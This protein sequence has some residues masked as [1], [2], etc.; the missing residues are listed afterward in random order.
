MKFRTQIIT[1]A[2]ALAIAPL[3]VSMTIFLF[4]LYFG[5]GEKKYEG[6]YLISR[7]IDEELYPL[8]YDSDADTI[9]I[10]RGI[11]LC[12]VNERGLIVFS[13]IP[14]IRKGM[15]FNP[16]LPKIIEMAKGKDS[17]TI[18][19]TFPFKGKRWR[20]FL[21]YSD[22]PEYLE[23]KKFDWIRKGLYSSIYLLVAGV[24][25]GSL[26]VRSILRTT[27][28]LEFAIKKISEGEL[29][30]TL[31]KKGKDEFA[32]IIESF[33]RMR[34]A[35]KEEHARKSRFLMAIS[36][37]LK[38]PLTSIRGYVEAI[39]DGLVTDVETMGR[40]IGIIANKSTVLEERISSLIDFA[41]M[42][43]GE[44][45]IKN[46]RIYLRSFLENLSR[47]Y[48]EDC[49]IL[50]KHYL[51]ECGISDEITVTGDPV[52]FERALE[53]LFVNS[54]RHTLSGT[55]IFFR[56]YIENDIPVI[57]LGDNGDGIDDKDIRYI[58]EPFYRGTNSRREQGMGLGLSTA[59]SIFEAHGWEISVSSE[60]GKGTV[61]RIIL[62]GTVI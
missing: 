23:N 26:I 50:D 25:A 11:E 51:F 45:K 49:E 62:H 16:L 6:R 54:V 36:H 3:V 2:T 21:V 39:Q 32:V 22:I 38:T 27:G 18:T 46:R 57:E 58:F 1:L 35:L 13:N 56:I 52:L 20:I 53:N 24:V 31:E 12:I 4:H 15:Y 44:W 19:E 30:F 59:K 10:P 61:F 14:Q 48:K 28:K 33:D 37:D 5:S 41:R 7:W 60:K 34:L 42:E 55:E 47:I 43:T 17:K 9:L 8:I 40:Y 29:D